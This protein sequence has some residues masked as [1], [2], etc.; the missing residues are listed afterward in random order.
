MRISDKMDDTK[1]FY[2]KGVSSLVSTI[3]TA[4]VI[5]ATLA[6]LPMQKE[7]LTTKVVIQAQITPNGEI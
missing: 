5:Y 1:N 3:D 7:M 4:H 6:I 2:G